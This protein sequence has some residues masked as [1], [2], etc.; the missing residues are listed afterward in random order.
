VVDDFVVLWKGE[1]VRSPIVDER[2]P[3]NPL[4]V[5]NIVE[6]VNK[7]SAPCRRE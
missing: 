7:L 1:A 6:F 2:V 5:D 4:L 3:V